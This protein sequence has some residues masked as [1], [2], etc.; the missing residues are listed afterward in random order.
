M[1][2]LACDIC[3][4]QLTMDASGEF[5]VCENCGMK[6]T[7]ERIQNKVQENI[8]TV[9]IEDIDTVQ[10]QVCNWEKMAMAAYDNTN[11]EEAYTYYCKILE[12]RVDNWMATFR[13]GM[14]IG[15]QS[16]LGNIRVNEVLGGAVD[17]TRLLMSDERQTPELVANGKMIMAVEIYK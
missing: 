9:K 2:G 15:W 6:H 17:A 3:G 4:A 14:C 1:A 13:K 10:E 8:G 16:S 5:A 12:K 11:Y 7:K